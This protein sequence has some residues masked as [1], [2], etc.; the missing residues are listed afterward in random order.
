ML[1]R[2]FYV[3]EIFKFLVVLVQWFQYELIVFNLLSVAQS[4]NKIVSIGHFRTL[5][6]SFMQTGVF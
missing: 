2:K 3:I 4:A 5:F 1:I 6:G